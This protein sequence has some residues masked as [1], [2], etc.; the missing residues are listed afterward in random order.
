[1]I[2]V[3]V[4]RSLICTELEMGKGFPIPAG[5]L[6]GARSYIDVLMLSGSRTREMW[7]KSPRHTLSHGT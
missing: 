7:M 2:R 4:L 5:V 1:M 3:K 6:L